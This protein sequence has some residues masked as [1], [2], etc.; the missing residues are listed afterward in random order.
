MTDTAAVD[1]VATTQENATE[2]KTLAQIRQER[3]ERL[4][5]PS[6]EELEAEDSETKNVEEEAEETEAVDTEETEDSDEGNKVQ[7]EDS[8][9]GIEGSED[10][11]VLSQIDW[12]S[13]SNEDSAFIAEQVGSG[14]GK[15][16]GEL[17]REIKS[18]KSELTSK[19]KAIAQGFSEVIPNNL[20]NA[21]S[22]EQLDN[23]EQSA[24]KDISFYQDWL[25]GD[26]LEFVHGE[27][28]YSRQ[29]IAAHLKQLQSQ[30]EEVPRQ[31]R[32]LEKVEAAK[33]TAQE[34]EDRMVESFVWLNDGKSKTDEAY[35]KLLESP[36]VAVIRQIAPAVAARLSYIMAHAAENMTKEKVKP[37]ARKIKLPRKKPAG[38]TAGSAER[39]QNPSTSMQARIK[40]LNKEV[41][42]GS[43]R[44]AR[45]LRILNIKQKH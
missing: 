4:S 11:D 32:Y 26:E 22:H 16:I 40:K 9:E 31:R 27:Q 33:K 30:L 38:N 34:E 15:R 3:I 6:A 1:D 5:P 12:E 24:K 39:S 7:P 41:E 45:E 14:A 18:L 43:L 10:T 28:S 21:R 8:E 44:A 37:P 23:I 42:G 2:E 13:L 17:T 25:A 19:D 36:D 29:D 35:Q 20:G